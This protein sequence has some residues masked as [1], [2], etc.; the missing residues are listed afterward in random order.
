[1]RVRPIEGD[2]NCLF[3]ALSYCVWRDESNYSLVREAIVN[4]FPNVW[5]HPKIQYSSK[6]WYLQK[7]KQN[8]YVQ[9]RDYTLTVQEYVDCST[10]NENKMYGGSTEL[11]TSA[12]LFSTPIYVYFEGNPRAPACSWVVY[13]A[14][15]VSLTTKCIALNWR[16]G[17]HFE[18]V[19]KM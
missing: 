5:P 17:N 18:V 7:T 3:R 19:N 16:L 14:E 9:L 13:G 12:H 4:H 8:P 10:M 2:G 15:F 6:S 11:E 1:M